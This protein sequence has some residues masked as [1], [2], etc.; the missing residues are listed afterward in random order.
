MKAV[1]LDLLLQS[2]GQLPILCGLAVQPADQDELPGGG[3]GGLACVQV[4]HILPEQLPQGGRRFLL[5]PPLVIL[6]VFQK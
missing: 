4:L 1:I 2:P 5:Q 6:L 3:G